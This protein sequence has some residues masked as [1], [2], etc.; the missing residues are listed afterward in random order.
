MYE[1]TKRMRGTV[2][3]IEIGTP[4]PP[5]NC[6]A[7]RVLVEQI[8]KKK[9]CS[10]TNCVK[11]YIILDHFV[12]LEILNVINYFRQILFGFVEELTSCKPILKNETIRKLICAPFV[13]IFN[14]FF[15]C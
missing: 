14:L 4:P 15:N 13:S 10:G 5:K 1:L 9:F 3:S 12:N 8:N 6:V 11:Q 7:T 2:V